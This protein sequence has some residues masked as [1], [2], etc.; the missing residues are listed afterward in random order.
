VLEHGPTAVLLPCDGLFAILTSCAEPK[1]LKRQRNIF[2]R[3]P[4][5]TLAALF[6]PFAISFWNG[7]SAA[8]LSQPE[9]RRYVE[10]AILRGVVPVRMPEIHEDPTRLILSSLGGAEIIATPRLAIDVPLAAQFKVSVA[11]R[12]KPRLARADQWEPNLAQA[13]GIIGAMLT[14]VNENP[15]AEA[16]ESLEG[17]AAQIDSLLVASWSTYATSISK[18]FFQERRAET[19]TVN[20]ATD[21]AMGI[22]RY[23]PLGRWDLYNALKEKAGREVVPPPDWI[24]VNQLPV[25]LAG[26]YYFSLEWPPDLGFTTIVDVKNNSPLKF[27][28]R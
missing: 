17:G 15:N 4:Q 20:I 5:L 23:M 28:K 22:V 25:T 21:P 3:V 16:P 24:E 27:K 1:V 14:T 13:E 19:Y 18:Q 2:M 10:A 8:Q 6:L 12:A 7:A 26:K 9:L 11:R